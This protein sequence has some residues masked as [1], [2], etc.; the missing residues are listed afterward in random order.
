MLRTLPPTAKARWPQVLR[1]QTFCYNCTIRE[2]TGF[3]PFYLM[4]GRVPC[5]PIDVMFQHVVHD[6]KVV[7]HN[8]FVAA[9]TGLE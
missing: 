5:L 4:Y 7:S 1:T 6:D 9:E 2:T 8:E 3:A